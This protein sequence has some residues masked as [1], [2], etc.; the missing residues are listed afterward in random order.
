[1]IAADRPP[2]ALERLAAV[3]PAD[4]PRLRFEL[5]PAVRLMSSPYPIFRIW[6]ANRAGGE[7]EVIDLAAG[8]EDVLVCREGEG[9]MLYRL[10]AAEFQCLAA[11]SVARPLGQA[12]ELA[13]GV[14]PDF[15][16]PGA[17]S[18][19]AALAVLADFSVPA[20][21]GDA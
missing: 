1:M 14:D 19:W 20:D 10:P 7:P 12:L 17:L 2:L 4:Y 9:V 16:L 3:P 8:G 15:D 13:T 11:L 18:R 5:S 6:A 21:S